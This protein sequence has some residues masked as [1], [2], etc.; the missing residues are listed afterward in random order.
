MQILIALINIII[1][2]AP[3]SLAPMQIDSCET[4]WRLYKLI[5]PD[6]VEPAA[7]LNIKIY[8]LVLT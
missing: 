4:A 7:I 8:E 2:L 3:E 6:C 1:N 5:Y